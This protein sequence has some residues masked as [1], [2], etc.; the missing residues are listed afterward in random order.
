[1]A[2]PAGNTA[3]RKNVEEPVCDGQLQ[4]SEVLLLCAQLRP[5]GSAPARDVMRYMTSSL[6]GNVRQAF[7]MPI[8]A[9]AQP[10]A[11]SYRLR[12]DDE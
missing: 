11:R 5:H 6:Y 4:G 2:A 3:S 9:V 8:R 1:M 12:D 7:L 10:L